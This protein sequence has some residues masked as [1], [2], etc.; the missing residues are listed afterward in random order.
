MPSIRLAKI[1]ALVNVA[2]VFVAVYY[3]VRV[4]NF[5]PLS[6]LP[7]KDMLVFSA[8]A[9]PPALAAWIGAWLARGETAERLLA[10]G[11][12]AALAVFAVALIAVLASDEP[13]APLFLILTSLW[14]ALGLIVLL[15]A[16]WLLGR[17]RRDAE[18]SQ[19]D[20]KQ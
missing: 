7:S 19:E 1:A 12:T 17:S 5:T 20:M 4:F 2:L 14:T 18:S 16:V 13:L 3:V 6:E 15:A 11:L 8:M 9:V 10:L